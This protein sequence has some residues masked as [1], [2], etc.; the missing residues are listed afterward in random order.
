[1]LEQHAVDGNFTNKN[2]FS[3]EAYFI[4]GGYVTKQN[5]RI[6]GSEDPQVIEE[7]PLHLEKSHCL[8]R[9]LDD[10]MTVTINSE[11]YGLMVTEIFC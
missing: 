6:W 11:R 9:S 4:L 8:M 2:F 7:R 3:D 10:G 5:C 1:M